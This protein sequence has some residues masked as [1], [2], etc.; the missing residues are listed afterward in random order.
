MTPPDSTPLSA[1]GLRRRAH[2]ALADLGLVTLGDVRTYLEQGGRLKQ[3]NVQGMGPKGWA[4]LG[5]VA[6]GRAA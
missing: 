6:E 3:L 5:Q 2:E 1:L 4:V